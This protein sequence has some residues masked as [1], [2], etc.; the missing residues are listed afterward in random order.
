MAFQIV[1]DL[2]LESPKAYDVFE[3]VPKAP[4]LALL[5]DI[6]N[7]VPHKEEV[8]AFLTTQLKQFRVVLFVPGNHE[9]YGSTW[10]ATYEI[11]RSFEKSVHSDDSLGEFILLDRGS[12]QV[13]GEKVIVLGC[14]LF[15]SVPQKDE[16]AVSFGVNDFFQ[17]HD[18][19]VAA[20]NEA[21]RKDLAWLN[22]RVR[23]L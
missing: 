13:P 22:D 9:A 20:H 2:H 12:F 1:S 3:I 18:W 14:S 6:G 10:A 11:M 4:Y 15:S 8:L 19:E 7:I 17:I 21:H 23:S 5:G 16:M